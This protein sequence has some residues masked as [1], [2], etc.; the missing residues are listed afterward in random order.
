[1]KGLI[2]LWFLPVAIFKWTMFSIHFVNKQNDS[3]NYSCEIRYVGRFYSPSYW[4]RIVILF[5][6]CRGWISVTKKLILKELNY[7][8]APSKNIF[9]YIPIEIPS[10]IRRL[11]FFVTI[12][13]A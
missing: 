13:I 4:L 2:S 5:F 10:M 3:A 8:L 9:G 1:M 11:Y 7:E 12:Y 6:K